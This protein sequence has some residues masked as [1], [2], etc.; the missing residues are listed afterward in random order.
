MI[1]FMTRMELPA[2]PGLSE[3]EL[4]DLRR[5]LDEIETIGMNSEIEE[6]T[7]QIR[8]SKTLK[9]PDAIIAATAIVLG[10]PLVSNDRAFRNI[11]GLE[12]ESF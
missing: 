10:S 6:A 11:A 12:V 1:S 8:R 2:Y 5:S 7:I 9:L 3:Q 4:L